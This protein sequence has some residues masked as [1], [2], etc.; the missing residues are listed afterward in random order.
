GPAGAGRGTEG[1]G[2]NVSE[3]TTAPIEAVPPVYDLQGV[4]RIFKN[5][6][7]TI[8][9]VDAIDLTIDGGEFVAI[10]GA[11]GSGK[12]TLLQLLGGLDRP[13]EGALY[14][15]GADVRR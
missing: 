10:E 13:T 12:S 7:A 3:P 6:P 14:L 15:D 8:R 4:S 5:G 1:P 2:V 9:A 11:S